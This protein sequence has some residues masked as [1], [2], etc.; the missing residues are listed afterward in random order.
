MNL[1]DVANATQEV[2]AKTAVHTAEQSSEGVFASLGING[3]LFIAQLINFAV[4]ALIIWYL[5]LKPLTKKMTERQDKI[6][7]SLK[8]AEEIEKK[9]QKSDRDYQEKIDQAKSQSAKI[10]EKSQQEVKEMG[11][12]MK[13]KTKEE[14]ELLINQ[15]KRNIQIEKDEMMV[16][17]KTKVSELVVAALEK[18]IE[19]KV[20][21][22]KDKD[23]ILK[24]IK[25]IKKI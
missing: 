17:V 15:A 5:I 12:K 18:I 11:D 22:A 20:D 2:V 4:V 21:D 13:N 19:E 14:I 9:L 24:S 7:A 10:M 3:S 25:G 6:D 1:I 8:N 16:E 23:M